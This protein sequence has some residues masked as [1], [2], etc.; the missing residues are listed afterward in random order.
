M[1]LVVEIILFL[2]FVIS[3]LL[4]IFLWRNASNPETVKNLLLLL[5]VLISAGYFIEALNRPEQKTT[6]EFHFYFDQKLRTWHWLNSWFENEY[7]PMPWFSG[8]VSGIDG[9]DGKVDLTL[10]WRKGM[11]LV[12][13]T[14]VWQYGERFPWVSGYE[15]NKNVSCV[16][17]DEIRKV[18]SHNNLLS[19]PKIAAPGFGFGLMVPNGARL[20][21]FTI[22]NDFMRTIE[23]SNLYF[24][25]EIAIRPLS[26][27]VAGGDWLGLFTKKEQ[28]EEFRFYQ[29]DYLVDIKMKSTWFASYNDKKTFEKWY[30]EVVS[31]LK[32]FD[33]DSMIDEYQKRK[34]IDASLKILSSEK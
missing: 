4:G 8:V 15:K 34:I 12:E 25:M 10:V 6:V 18:F 26:M 24:Q 13:K 29:L 31:K 20:K 33:W 5:A 11:D 21:S 3:V 27:S 14:V 19:D 23:I 1:T 28:T 16:S 32:R 2:Y 17:Q 9:K 22:D 7:R 30:E